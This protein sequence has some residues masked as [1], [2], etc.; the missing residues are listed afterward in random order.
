[1]KTPKVKGLGRALKRILLLWAYLTFCG[2]NMELKQI[3]ENVHYI[4][5]VTNIGVIK[6]GEAAVLIDS[7]VDDDTGRR[8]MRLL[9][10]Q[11]LQLKAIIN[12]HFHAD[13]CGGNAYLKNKTGAVIYASEVEADFIQHPYLQPFCL[14][15]GANPPVELQNKLV[16]AT[17]SKVDYIIKNEEK[18]LDVGGIRVEIVRLPGHSPNQIGVKINDVV[19]SADAVFSEDILNKHKLPY[20]VNVEKQKETLNCLKALNTKLLVP[21]HGEPANDPV[22]MVDAYEKIINDVEGYLLDMLKEE[23]TTEQAMK[24]LCDRHDV[25]VGKVNQYFLMHTITL[26]YLSCLRNKGQLVLAFRDNILYW[27]KQ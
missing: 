20:L 10:S 27:R 7:G 1:M 26:A 17:P 14:F 11:H 2:D 6:S 23:K 12:T 24:S 5:H 18:T 3:A 9:E 16:M 13:H 22:P 19:F 4:P 15:S 21:S 25:E 8:I